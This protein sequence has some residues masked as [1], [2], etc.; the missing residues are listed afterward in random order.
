M[1]VDMGRRTVPENVKKKKKNRINAKEMAINFCLMDRVADLVERQFNS[2]CIPALFLISN[3]EA[4]SRECNLSSIGRP[5]LKL[6]V[7]Y[8]SKTYRKPING[9]Y[10][11]SRL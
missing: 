2:L 4:R 8:R 9:L 3:L 6:H 11:W 7:F 10:S 5:T 1:D